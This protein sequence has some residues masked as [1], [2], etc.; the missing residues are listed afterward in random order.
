M[1]IRVIDNRKEDIYSTQDSHN[2]T[3]SQLSTQG[4]VI[5]TIA[6][7][8]IN[9]TEIPTVIL[10]QKIPLNISIN[11]HT[12]QIMAYL[13]RLWWWLIIIT[14]AIVTVIAKVKE[15]RNKGRLVKLT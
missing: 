4:G 2:H 1:L 15:R 9:K 3:H 12:H 11:H 5:K 6:I 8:W 13:I 7:I 14:I 10:I